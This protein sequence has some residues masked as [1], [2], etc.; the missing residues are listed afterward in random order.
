MKKLLY[1]LFALLCLCACEPGEYHGNTSFDRTKICEG[2]G[3]HVA[4]TIR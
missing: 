1:I 2:T 3:Y 4:Y